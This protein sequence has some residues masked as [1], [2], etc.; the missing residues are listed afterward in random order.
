MR[1][2]AREA[3]RC[4]ERSQTARPSIMRCP[5]HEGLHSATEGAQVK[6][7]GVEPEVR[8]VAPLVMAGARSQAIS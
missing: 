5:L 1:A 8:A 2:Q 3:G 6:Q 7:V 4:G